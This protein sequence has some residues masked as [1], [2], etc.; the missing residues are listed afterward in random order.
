MEYKWKMGDLVMIDGAT[1]G[2][3][4]VLFG[5]MAHVLIGGGHA[6]VSVNQNQL[7]PLD[8]PALASEP[9]AVY[10]LTMREDVCGIFDSLGLAKAAAQRLHEVDY[11]GDPIPWEG[12]ETST[13]YGEERGKDL[14]HITCCKPNK[15][16]YLD[17]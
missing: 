5:D 13:L 7:T 2:E 1:P 16:R 17:K 8:A 10:V 4:S 14:Y 6:S 12:D 9:A 15:L 3:I 11:P